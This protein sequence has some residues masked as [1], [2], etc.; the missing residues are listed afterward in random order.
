F[1]RA[2]GPLQFRGSSG[3]TWLD[4]VWRVTLS[5]PQFYF[6]SNGKFL[7]V[8]ENSRRRLSHGQDASGGSLIRHGKS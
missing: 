6:L 2:S 8:Y 4:P 5:L 1:Q 7:A 3:W